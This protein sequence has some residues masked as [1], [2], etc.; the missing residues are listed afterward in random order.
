MEQLPFSGTTG[1]RVW[2]GRIQASSDRTKA[3]HG[4]AS[5]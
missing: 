4:I 2:P 1:V 3:P 5:G